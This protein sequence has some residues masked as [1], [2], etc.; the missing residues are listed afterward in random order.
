M[1]FLILYN[2]VFCYFNYTCVSCICK[3]LIPLMFSLITDLCFKVA[4]FC[5]HKIFIKLYCLFKI[6]YHIRTGDNFK[7][8]LNSR[9]VCLIANSLSLSFMYCII[10]CLGL[11]LHPAVSFN[12]ILLFYTYGFFSL[13]E[14]FYLNIRVPK[15]S[16]LIV[17]EIHKE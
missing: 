10:M 12:P 5:N 11:L 6:H 4:F 7:M 1:L 15:K 17:W 8:T 14:S 2:H 13:K 16:A 3:S 9:S